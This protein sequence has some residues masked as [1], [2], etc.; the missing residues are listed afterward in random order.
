MSWMG[1]GALELLQ[2]YQWQGLWTGMHAYS[3]KQLDSWAVSRRIDG[4][5]AFQTN[6][7]WNDGEN[8]IEN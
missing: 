1:Y 4:K 8:Y 5:G 6:V 7:T 2:R 3:T